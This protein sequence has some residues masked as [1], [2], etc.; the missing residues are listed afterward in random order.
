MAPLLI[1]QWIGVAL[2]AIFG[3]KIA[4]NALGIDITAF[5]AQANPNASRTAQN[6]Q[7]QGGGNGGQQAPSDSV[8][9]DAIQNPSSIWALAALGFVGVFVVSQ[10]RAAGSEAAAGVRGVYRE[11]Q[12]G[13]GT[14]K[15]PNAAVDG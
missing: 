3:S 12:A 15:N 13:V 8:V 10:L 7:Q 1:L 9:R 4:G 2:A 14:L 11:A 5:T 6:L